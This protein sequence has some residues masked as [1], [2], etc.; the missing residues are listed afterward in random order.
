M[1]AP[2]VVWAMQAPT[3]LN[4]LARATSWRVE[5]ANLGDAGGLS[6]VQLSQAPR[7]DGR[8]AGV[9]H[10]VVCTP[11]QWRR[12]R[13]MFPSARL[14][15]ALHCGKPELLPP[16][17]LARQE[18]AP[19]LLMAFSY[20][21]AAMQE[22]HVGWQIDRFVHVVVP[23]YEPAPVW[24]PRR[25]AAWALINRPESRPKNRLTRIQ[26]VAELAR[27]ELHVFGQNTPGG[28]LGPAER[29]AWLS[30]ST[31]Y[32]S[33][34]RHYAGFGLSEHEC[35]AAGVPV[36]GSRWGDMPLEMPDAYGLSDDL[37]QLGARL[38]TFHEHPGEAQR[39]SEIGLQFIR[40]HRQLERTNRDVERLLSAPE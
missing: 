37:R 32:V 8:P 22:A 36:I 30:S 40:D 38:R 17:E 5:V 34:L 27:L 19:P 28:F 1:T 11:L 23:P 6:E 25:W 3:L 4:Q 20:R 35:F 39:C 33:A 7:W 12:A 18:P 29:L 15:W 2:R 9:T 10:V 31:A 24:R 13:S 21:V 26:R 14:V 16:A